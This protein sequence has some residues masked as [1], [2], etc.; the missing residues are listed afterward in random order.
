[1]PFREK[2]AWIVLVGILGGSAV[3]FGT[4]IAHHMRPDHGFFIGL[5]VKVVIVQCILSI[6]ATVLVSIF[7][8]GDAGA[9]RD[10]RDRQIER[11]AAGQSYQPL[12]IGVIFAAVSIHL[13]N[14]LFGMLN[15]LLA[16]IM[17]A[18]ALRFALQIIA[19]RRGA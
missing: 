19:Y 12:L 4:L 17:A 5:F 8:R 7:S 13:G 2:I 11:T 14:D 9:P 1:M 16:V 18:E 3:Y 6:A 15:T 10:E